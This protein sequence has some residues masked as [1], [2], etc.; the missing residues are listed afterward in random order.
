[1]KGADVLVALSKPGPDTVK[2]EWIQ[3]MAPNS[4]VFVCANPIPEIWPW[5]AKEA[6]AKVVATGRSDF[7]NQVNNSL[8][9]PGIFRGALDV[10]AKTISDGMCIRAAEEIAKI[11]EEKGLSDEYIIP[12]MTELEVFYRVAAVVGMKAIEEGIARITRTYD[13]LYNMAKHTILES[14][15]MTKVLM[16]SE[17]IPPYKE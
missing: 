4:I 8:G 13:E 5:V 6:G 3:S 11:A 17:I 14:Q 1:L 9:F 2:P 12:P 7:P 16:D 10:N 15:R